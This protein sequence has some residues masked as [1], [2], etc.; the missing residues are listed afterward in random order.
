[1]CVFYLFVCLSASAAE[2]TVSPKQA[3]PRHPKAS[4]GQMTRRGRERGDYIVWLKQP[5]TNVSFTKRHLITAFQED[6]L[7]TITFV[8]STHC[9]L[10]SYIHS[11]NS[12]LVKEMLEKKIWVS[13]Q[14][15]AHRGNPGFPRA[16]IN[17]LI[18]QLRLHFLCITSY[19][20]SLNSSLTHSMKPLFPSWHL[21]RAL[22]KAG[23]LDPDTEEAF[24]SDDCAPSKTAR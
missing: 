2:K 18:L 9:N 5:V 21:P 20:S 13:S 1:M 11:Y 3:Q 4:P 24:I 15:K 22:I 10:F 14:L 16:W 12:F 6:L 8:F 23:R 19:P 17:I 7:C